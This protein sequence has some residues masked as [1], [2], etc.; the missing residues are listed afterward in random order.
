MPRA[1]AV[2]TR[3]TDA[4]PVAAS[5]PWYPYPA[6]VRP[7]LQ[8]YVRL[9]LQASSWSRTETRTALL[10][11]PGSG[12][13]YDV[14]LKLTKE[15]LTV[16]KQDVLCVS[17]SNHS[18]NWVLLLNPV[19]KVKSIIDCFEELRSLLVDVLDNPAF[20]PPDAQKVSAG[21]SG[22]IVLHVGLVPPQP[23]L[24]AGGP[25]GRGQNRGSECPH[26]AGHTRETLADLESQLLCRTW[27]PAGDRASR[28]LLLRR[29][30][31][32]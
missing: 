5:W 26:A 3:R 31:C 17:G 32:G 20:P 19:G 23:S 22:L 12:H 24:S 11:D 16:Q 30:L 29:T 2:R 1:P 27:G 4:G 14:R 10:R 18:A 8:V 7:V 25:Q 15:V 6:P 28:L 21:S 13:A 9:Q